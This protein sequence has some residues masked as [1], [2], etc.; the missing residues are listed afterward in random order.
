MWQRI[1]ALRHVG[2]SKM[3]GRALQA[4]GFVVQVVKRP[5]ANFPRP[6]SIQIW[7]GDKPN[8]AFGDR[9]GEAGASWRHCTGGVRV[10]APDWF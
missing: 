1:Y 5:E 6:P 10:Q 9:D 7:H 2:S 3:A 4:P 8:M